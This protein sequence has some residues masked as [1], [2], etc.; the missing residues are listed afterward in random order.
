MN[1]VLPLFIELTMRVYVFRLGLSV[2]VMMR[3]PT[4]NKGF[5][6]ALVERWHQEISCF[7][8]HVKEMTITLDDVSCLLHLSVTGR[9]IDHVPSTFTREVVKVLFMTRLGILIEIIRVGYHSLS[10]ALGWQYDIFRQSSTHVN[11]S[12]LLYLNNLGDWHWYA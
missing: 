7:H 6:N 11:V 3:Y 2:L 12:Y 5:M 10:F 8:L 1:Q 4:A 9:P